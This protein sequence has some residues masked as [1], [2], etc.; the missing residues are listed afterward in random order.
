[1]SFRPKKQ[2]IFYPQTNTIVSI[3]TVCI[4]TS[5]D[6]SFSKSQFRIYNK[7][8]DPCNQNEC[9]ICYDEENTIYLECGHLF[10]AAC[11]LKMLSSRSKT[12]TFQCPLCR[13]I[14]EVDDSQIKSKLK[15]LVK[16]LSD[17]TD[18]KNDKKKVE[19][20]KSSFFQPLD[21]ASEVFHKKRKRTTSNFVVV[22]GFVC[23]SIFM[24]QSKHRYI[25]IE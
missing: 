22:S 14:Q 24:K 2:I 16:Q 3:F 1:M 11:I 6:H 12:Q 13:S 10:G 17:H 21:G 23:T 19:N 7:M 8:T 5:S 9:S 25:Q 15:K 18:L 4:Q 20:S